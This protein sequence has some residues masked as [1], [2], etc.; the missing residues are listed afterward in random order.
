MP[1][2]NN[3]G[4]VSH[5]GGSDV[6]SVRDAH[7]VIYTIAVLEAPNKRFGL[8]VYRTFPD[9]RSEWV[10]LP[11][12]TEGRAGVSIEPD[13]M[14]LSWPVNRDRHITRVKVPG[15]VTPNY[16]GGTQSFLPSPITV[17]AQDVEARANAS[18]ALKYAQDE[19]KKL[20]AEV[21][22]LKN[23]LVTL[24]ARPTGQLTEQEILDRIWKVSADRFYAELSNSDSPVSNL[25]RELV[26]GKR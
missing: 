13:G 20:N 15:F 6:V 16:P 21:K 2:V 26:I 9:G 11:E 8:Y 22:K 17:A 5:Y 10:G 1:V 4:S 3:P 7:N 14:Y 19:I 24:A 25:I 23:D 18:N 12:T